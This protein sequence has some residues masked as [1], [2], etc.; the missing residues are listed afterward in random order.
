METLLEKKPL[1]YYKDIS[2]E[3]QIVINRAPNGARIYLSAQDPY[4]TL[5]NTDLII[6]SIKSPNSYATPLSNSIVRLQVLSAR[7]TW[8]T[9]NV[10]E[11][12]NTLTIFASTTASLHSVTIP[13][14]FYT[15]AELLITAI[16]TALNTITGTTGLVFAKTNSPKSPLI[17][18]L[19]AAG[20]TY[21]ISTQCSA[22]KFGEQLYN[23]PNS[24]VLSTSYLV[25]S[26][27]MRYTN[28]VDICSRRLQQYAKHKNMTTGYNSDIVVRIY[29][30][31]FG[32]PYDEG[33]SLDLSPCFA[34]EPT[35]NLTSID[36]QIKDQFGQ[37]LYVP[38]GAKG[39]AS[40]FLWDMELGV[41][42]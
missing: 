40:G 37:L 13:E 35:D 1:S 38:Q 8:L 29:I 7:L 24:E 17:F 31:E 12:N 36:F 10:N 32:A 25:G 11:R 21:Y 33:V 39:T 23:F 18:D 26:M 15:T 6:S 27:N 5:N 30:D 41:Q 2:L 19:Y 20:G 22:F 9:P 3:P 16:V 34:Y 42:I 14:G 28:F 4:K